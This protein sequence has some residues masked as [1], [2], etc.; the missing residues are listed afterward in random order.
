MRP[1]EFPDE[2]AYRTGGSDEVAIEKADA[3]AEKRRLQTRFV[4]WDI[5]TYSLNSSTGKGRLIPHFL[6]AA[7][8][9]CDCLDSKF[10]KQSC[11]ICGGLHHSDLCLCRDEW[12]ID[13]FS[14]RTSCWAPLGSERCSTCKQQQFVVRAGSEKELF[15]LFTEWLMRGEM[16]GFT[17]LAHG[18]SG[19]DSPYLF[20]HLIENY[21]VHIDTIYSGTRLLEFT[22]KKSESS[23]TP[24]FRGIDTAAFFLAPLKSLPKQF[25]LDLDVKK[26]Y[27]PYRFDSPPNWNYCG[28]FPDLDFFEP[29]KM[30]E[31]ACTELK[32][33]YSLQAQNEFHFRK[34]MTDY[35]LEDV[36]VLLSAVQVSSRE[37]LSVIGFNGLAHC[38]TI[39]SKAMM[40]FRHAHLR[41]NEI[42]IIG[43]SGMGGFKKQSFEGQLWILLQELDFPGLQHARSAEGERVI[44]FFPVDG[45]HEPSNSVFQFHGCFW[46]GCPT[47]FK[48][49]NA[50]N[51]VNLK[52]FDELYLNTTRRTRLMRD[53][54]FTVIEKWSC[55]FSD[56]EK[57]RALSLGL[58][59]KV[60][61][62]QPSDAFYGGRTDAVKLFSI[63]SPDESILYYDVTSEYPFVNA[64]KSYPMGYPSV[65]L[66]HQLPQSNSEWLNRN[67]L[68]LVQCSIVAPSFL[69]HPVLPVKIKGR[70]HFPLCSSCVSSSSDSRVG[71]L[72]CTHSD[73]ERSLSGTWTTIEVD[74]ALSLG[75]RLIEV[76][77]VWHFAEQSDKLFKGFIM[78]LY[79]LKL[80]ASGFPSDVQTGEQKRSYAED[81]EEN[82]GVQLNLSNV[83]FNAGRRQMAKILLNSFWGK[84]GQRENLTQVEFITEDLARF[85][86]LVFSDNAY[87]VL[88]VDLVSDNVA[89]VVYKPCFPKPNPKGNIVV[90]LWTTALARLHLYENAL[91]KLGPRV[92]Y[93]DTDSVVF[94]HKAGQWKPSLSNYLGGWTDEIPSGWKIVKFITCGP[95]NY[96]YEME[97]IANGIRKVVKKVKGIRL[98]AHAS[99]LISLNDMEFQVTLNF[100]HYLEMFFLYFTFYFRCVTFVTLTSKLVKDLQR[101]GVL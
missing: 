21:G 101:G 50:K 29:S 89:Y 45:F 63:P 37:D 5:E 8:V 85:N 46:H 28:S 96:G 10:V 19:F 79:R 23:K 7:T 99:Q 94:R 67:Y 9:C 30:S 60:A 71:S 54:G 97:N 33:W 58:D 25:G 43:Q 27:F 93:M 22:V 35:C 40:H 69:C 41:P 92:M 76:R 98:S 77:E 18:G 48:D 87:E 20:R 81:I 59:L 26:G 72:F 53:Q 34:E 3:L 42:G 47:C 4:I 83:N 84:W 75:Y 51:S 49:R 16:F 90:A 55:S 91:E 38:C 56:D 73:D 86:E 6:A 100:F 31:S 44:C 95:K 57:A 88:F 39:A 13:N 78:E 14:M 2:I 17:L 74:K 52:S 24:F 80:E 12:R 32:E 61:Q 15:R 62:L 66:K 1:F 65:L 11:S 70:L 82:E 36:R 68:G 64:M